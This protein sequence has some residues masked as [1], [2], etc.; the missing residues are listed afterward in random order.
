MATFF[1]KFS[2]ILLKKEFHE[3]DKAFLD[4]YCS[5]FRAVTAFPDHC[6]D[7]DAELTDARG[8]ANLCIFR[9]AVVYVR[10]YFYAAVSLYRGYCIDRNFKQA[11]Y[12]EKRA[13]EDL[14]N[15]YFKYDAEYI[16]C[17]YYYGIDGIGN[18]VM[19]K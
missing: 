2:L 12:G 4:I 14:H 7:H 8:I 10:C 11:E 19:R 6:L 5:K 13:L 9:N 3:K 16:F 15:G 18:D 17:A 1:R